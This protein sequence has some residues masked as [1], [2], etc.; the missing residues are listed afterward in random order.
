MIIIVAMMPI[1]CRG[2][3]GDGADLHRSGPR[4]QIVPDVS[5]AFCPEPSPLETRLSDELF[6]LTNQLRAEGVACSPSSE[7]VTAQALVRSSTLDCAARAHSRD[8]AAHGFFSHANPM[9]L[10]PQERARAFS[11]NEPVAENVAWGQRTA[12]D[13][14]EAWRSSPDHCRSLVDSAYA[15]AG[16][17]HALSTTG[18]P[19]WT[20]FL[21]RA[22][23]SMRSSERADERSR[24]Q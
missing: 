3:P 1:G 23:P 2:A 14:I 19:M 11:F 4:G 16:V 9:G 6:A 20:Q 7:A 8:M 21:G 10:G 22:T 12:E 15:L 24:S 17:G 13:V 18:K 5:Q